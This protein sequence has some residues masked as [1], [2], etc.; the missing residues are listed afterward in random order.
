[1]NTP[2]PPRPDLHFGPYRL[3]GRN[4]LLWHQDRV[5]P[6]SPKATAVLG[7]LASRAGQLVTKAEPFQAVWPDT[8]VSDGV[9]AVG[10]RELRRA[11]DD[12]AQ[13]PRY[14]ETIHRRG[15]RFIETVT[16]A[17]A[18]VDTLGLSPP[19]PVTSGSSSL[20]TQHSALGPAAFVGRAAE[21]AHLT[22]G[23]S[24]C[25]TWRRRPR[26]WGWCIGAPR[27]IPSSWCISWT[28]WPSRAP[29]L[30]RTQ[31]S[32]APPSYRM[33]P[34]CPRPCSP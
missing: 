34:P 32:G 1:M 15:Y 22:R 31:P 12:A 20:S 14:I 11:L 2:L 28:L 16:A 29:S 9:L 7:C 23:R 5:V 6:L 18:G 3:D 27:G 8:A 19:Q 13:Q 33:R 4:G 26:S 25:P 17:P 21:L 30:P 24:G 10:I